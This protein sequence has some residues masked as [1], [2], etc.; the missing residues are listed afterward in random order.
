[1]TAKT[2][3]IQV[4]DDHLERIAQTRNPILALAELIWNAVDADATH[5]DVTLVEDGLYGLKIIRVADNG[6]GIPFAQ[7]EELFS[8]LGGSWKQSRV[9]SNEQKRM[10]HGKAGKG[11][12]RAF[13]LGR[14]VD[15]DV[16]VADHSDKLQCYHISMLKDHLRRVQ[17]TDASPVTE[18]RDRGVT[19]T[20]SEP[21][22]DFRSLHGD[23]VPDELAQ[24]FALSLRQ[25]PEVRIM[26]GGTTI[27][28]RSAEDLSTSYELPNIETTDGRVFPASLEI[29]EWR[30]KVERKLFFCDAN[31]F[32]IDDTSLGIH[33]PGFE[34][35]AYVKSD[36]FAELLASNMLDLANMDPAV[37][38]CL[39]TAKKAMRDHFRQ[40]AAEKAAGLVE[41]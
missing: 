7:A 2:F 34:F 29:V 27:D 15:W 17:I 19:V 4:Q 36:Y 38:K 31:G 8:R 16:C 5:I 25:Y 1:M 26:Y 21:E 12:F 9:H 20:V 14:V 23:N 24:I 33:A 11:R 41:E 18:G 35:T 3:D 10:L 40:R 28:S 6:H 30:I 32:P 39:H 13:S 37:D 22:R